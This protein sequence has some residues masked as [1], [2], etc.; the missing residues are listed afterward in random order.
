[1]K[2]VEPGTGSTMRVSVLV[3]LGAIAFVAAFVAV[4]AGYPIVFAGGVVIT[5]VVTAWLAHD[6]WRTRTRPER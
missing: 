1:M 2:R 5:L 4:E 3:A 6:A